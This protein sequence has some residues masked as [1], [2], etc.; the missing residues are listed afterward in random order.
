MTKSEYEQYKLECDQM[1]NCPYLKITKIVIGF[2]L[3]GLMSVI[4]YHGVFLGKFTNNI[5]F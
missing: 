1:C 5:N 3:L 2:V 4:L